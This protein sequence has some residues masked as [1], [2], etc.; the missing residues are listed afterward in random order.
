MRT[1]KRS[2]KRQK[3]NERSMKKSVEVQRGSVGIFSAC[4]RKMK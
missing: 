3:Y 1:K 2:T 4:E